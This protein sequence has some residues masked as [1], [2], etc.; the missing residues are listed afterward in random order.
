LAAEA[1]LQIP[2]GS[3][4]HS[5]EWSYSC[6]RPTQRGG[7]DRKGNGIEGKGVK[8]KGQ[9]KGVRGIMP[10]NLTHYLLRPM[11]LFSMQTLCDTSVMVIWR[12]W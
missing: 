5:A 7:L 2:L 1:L 4:Q 12:H 10:A 6:V 9:R 11:F 8:G 3:L